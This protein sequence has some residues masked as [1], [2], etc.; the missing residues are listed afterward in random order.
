MFI[1]R[2]VSLFMLMLI[3][4]TVLSCGSA[5]NGDSDTNKEENGK[6]DIDTDV[7][8]DTN[9]DTNTDTDTGANS[10]TEDNTDSDTDTDTNTDIDTDM[11]TETDTDVGIDTDENVKLEEFGNFSTVQKTV[12]SYDRLKQMRLSEQD[13]NTGSSYT[14]EQLSN[15]KLQAKAI[16]FLTFMYPNAAKAMKHFLGG[17]GE[18]FT[19]D[20]DKL[21]KNEIAKQN[22]INDMNNALRAAENLAVKNEKVTIYQVEESIHHNLTEDWKYTLGSYFTSIELYDV[23]EKSLLGVPYYT[24]KVK[25][26]VQDFYNWDKNDYN[27]V[28]ILKVSP[29]D[30]HQLH[31][32]GE[33]QEFLSYGEIEYEIKWA[34]GID[35][36]EIEILSK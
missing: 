29:A 16:T 26:I 14:E 30:L 32:N 19:V 23:E 20:V 4:V 12:L 18:N 34:K 21:L 6:S 9:A 31:V 36:S 2:L 1:K 22:M 27:N 3:L 11:D 8:A 13:Y 35:A 10:D 7:N 15:T 24:A 33:A 28:S 25:Y 17:T 5:Q